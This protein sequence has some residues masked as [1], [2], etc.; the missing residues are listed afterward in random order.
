M[1][2][3]QKFNQWKYLESCPES[4]QKQLYIKGDKIKVSDIYSEMIFKKETLE[5]A[6]ENRNLPLAAIQE[7]I[8]YC[9][10]YRELLKEEAQ[11]KKLRLI[12]NKAAQKRSYQTIEWFLIFFLIIILIIIV[13]NPR[14]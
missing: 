13:Q 10:I 9:Q 2:R 7:V 5:E 4:W 11:E 8:E 1:T 3:F 6:A 12:K 14:I